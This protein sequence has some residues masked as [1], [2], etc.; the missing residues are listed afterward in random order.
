MGIYIKMEMPEACEL[1]CIDISPNGKVSNHY[2]L[3]SK[4]I[5]IAVPVPKHG[6]L[7]DADTLKLD[8]TR[9]YDGEVTAKRLIDEQSTIIP[10]SGG[11]EDE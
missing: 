2:D 4:E 8:L 11:A 9:F 1:L 5:A 10:A 7:I 6:R 3:A